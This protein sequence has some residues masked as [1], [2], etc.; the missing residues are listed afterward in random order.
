MKMPGLV[1]SS[2][3]LAVF[4][5]AKAEVSAQPAAARFALSKPVSMYVGGTPGGSNDALA[6][7]VARHLGKYL[8]GNPTV[9]PKNM[10]GAGGARVPA[11]LSS[12]ALRDGTE[13]GNFNRGVV[14][15]PMVIHSTK[16]FQ[17]EQLLW[18]GSPSGA[19][20]ICAVWHTVPVKSV[21]DTLQR[22]LIIGVTG[23]EIAH[24]LLLQRLTGGKLRPITGYDS[25]GVNL[26]MERGEVEA[27]CGLSWE[28]MKTVYPAW[29]TEKKV[30]IITQFA[31]DKH[32]ELPQVPLITEFATH[33]L[34]QQA[35][36]ILMAPNLIGYPFAAPPGLLP[37]V[38]EM[39][40]A[41][42]DKVWKDPALVADA[43][44][45]DF[46][47]NPVSGHTIQKAIEQAYS[48]P[49]QTIERAK[50]LTALRT[51]T[52]Q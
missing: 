28:S 46:S 42:F 52:P 31:M 51:D 27:R 38:K 12:V 47:V 7:I 33:A 10:A 48:F 26:A 29:I 14:L 9:V 18:L 44:K 13:F 43:A 32:P 15:D 35:L 25:K 11:Y 21:A 3:A 17:P 40:L 22:E 4:C 45:I 50:E 16:S 39:L 20:D 24:V 34:D 36:R 5:G 19:T 30:S 1:C 8:P 23:P 49:A 6:R 41:A 37:E 2:L